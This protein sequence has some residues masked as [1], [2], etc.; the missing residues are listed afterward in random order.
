MFKLYF[1]DVCE[2]Q[3]EGCQECCEHHELDHSICLDCG[4]ELDPGLAI[5]RAMDAIDL[6]RD[7]G[8]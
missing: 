4:K 1:Q 8:Y 6:N 5:D 3:N 2:C 7:G